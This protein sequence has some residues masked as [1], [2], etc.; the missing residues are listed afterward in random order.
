MADDQTT[1]TPPLI[2]HGSPGSNRSPYAFDDN[3]FR[4]DDDIIVEEQLDNANGDHTHLKVPQQTVTVVQ[5]KPP[6]LFTQQQQLSPPQPIPLRDP[7]LSETMQF[8]MHWSGLVRSS[9]AA[10]LAHLCFT[11]GASVKVEARATIP[12]LIELLIGEQEE[13]QEVPPQALST[14][15]T[16]QKQYLNICS[17]LRNLTNGN[18]E[19][20]HENKGAFLQAGG[21]AAIGRLFAHAYTLIPKTILNEDKGRIDAANDVAK[22]LCE[23]A[24]AILL[25]LS[26]CEQ[27]Q[28]PI[29]A[30]ALPAILSTITELPNSIVALLQKQQQ[31]QQTEQSSENI[32]YELNRIKRSQ[33]NQT[34]RYY[35]QQLL[36]QFQS[37][38]FRFVSG[39]LR[40]VSSV[41]DETVRKALR[42]GSDDGALLRAIFAYVRIVCVTA[43][44]FGDD[45]VS[46]ENG[47]V[48]IVNS[49]ATENCVC[50][51]RNISYR[52]QEIDDDNYD[53]HFRTG[54][55]EV[56]YS[57]KHNHHPH[58]V[59]V[60]G[61]RKNVKKT[62]SDASVTNG[63]KEDDDEDEDIYGPDV[64]CVLRKPKMTRQ[65]KTNLA[66][67]VGE[68]LPSA[69][70][71]RQ[72]DMLW[73][74]EAVKCY[75]ALLRQCTNMSTLEAAAGTIQNLTACAWRPASFVRALV[76]KEKGL[77]ILIEL[78]RMDN[79]RVVMTVARALR[80]LA[81]DEKNREL[82]GKYAMND[83]MTKI[84]SAQQH[85]PSGQPIPTVQ[86]NSD[87]TVA[88][89]LATLNETIASNQEFARIFVEH[90]G[91][92]KLLKIAQQ[93]KDSTG[94]Y[95]PKSVR[96]ATYI[97]HALWRRHVKL[98]DLYK[99][100]GF[101]E[102]QLL[103]VLQKGHSTTELH[104]VETQRR[105][106]KKEDEEIKQESSS[107]LAIAAE[108][109][110]RQ[111]EAAEA[112]ALAAA[113]VEVAVENDG[114]ELLEEEP[115]R[116][117]P[118]T[119]HQ[120]TMATT[121]Y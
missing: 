109:R 71:A 89:L 1:D 53:A 64:I 119:R 54:V 67:N 73:S 96:F 113:A 85:R 107:L 62:T 21:V 18:D 31:Q 33:T 69:A 78:L 84:F 58:G 56:F 77:P 92:A 46:G 97:L 121:Q 7:T 104:R 95:G 13:E 91:L 51:I 79:D 94:V 27:I 118:S 14:P 48:G 36:Q 76:R 117:A 87:D 98:R 106:Q 42:G 110:K 70:A 82:I 90:G 28:K 60:K 4:Y 61:G 2:N 29:V 5:Q 99:T 74:T 50:L 116:N 32:Q 115:Q 81:I 102:S 10:H 66:I 40:N 22:E 63:S 72:V 83:L 75:L 80:N 17:A 105:R 6:M 44:D 45:S 112:D 55:G 108:E 120:Y 65:Q 86:T 3:I 52:L 16:A 12:L 43:G 11:G 88:A 9:A 57:R 93:P 8:L 30:E 20:D 101:K 111:A 26:S 39:V 25:N 68:I 47:V 34:L 103:A 23:V 114:N 24:S 49:K 59:A 37:K 38:T 41:D 100:F 15:V 35:N 19:N